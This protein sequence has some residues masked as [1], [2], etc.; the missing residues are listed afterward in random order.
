MYAVCFRNVPYQS[1]VHVLYIYIYI[2]NEPYESP[3]CFV[4]LL[5]YDYIVYTVFF[6]VF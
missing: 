6:I 5:F 2:Y 1:S 4:V 3:I